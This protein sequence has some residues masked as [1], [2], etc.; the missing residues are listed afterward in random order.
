MSATIKRVIAIAGCK[1]GVGKTC[2]AVNLS[3]A[4]IKQGKRVVLMDGDL[5]VPDISASMGLY[6]DLPLIDDKTIPVHRDIRVLNAPSGLTVL[7]P[8]GEIPWRKTTGV[9]DSVQ[10][11]NQLDILASSLDTLIIDTAPGL[12][13]DNVT[14][15]QAASEV[16]IIITQDT[17]SLLDG[18]RLICQLYRV[19]GVNHFSVIVNAVSNRK[20]GQDQFEKLQS[21]LAHFNQVI[22]CYLGS[23]PQDRAVTEALASQ[24]AVFHAYPDSKAAKAFSTV[25]HN[26]SM[27][28]ALPPKGRVEFFTPARIK[29]DCQ[30]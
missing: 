6:P 18:V 29:E 30:P 23:I 4:L 5:S 28:P 3:L 13:P 16:I 11:I 1:G 8:V 21:K 10:L 20:K 25:A 27:M 17:L 7:S 12:G 2:I 14:L 19:Y 26:L 22:L 24:S 9:N 15:I